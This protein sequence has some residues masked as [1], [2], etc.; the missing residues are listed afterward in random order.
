MLQ[1]NV[2]LPPRLTG[3]PYPPAYDPS[4]SP[5]RQ[6]EVSSA[7]LGVIR[8]AGK[9]LDLYRFWGIVQQAGGSAKV[10][11]C[12]I[13]FAHCACSNLMWQLHQQGMWGQLLPHLDLPEQ[14]LGPNGQ[15]QSTAQVL[16]QYY[17]Q[18]LS[19]FE[20]AY[21][22]N[23]RDQR[24]QGRPQAGFPMPGAGQG[25]ST[26]P[27]TFPPVGNLPAMTGNHDPGMLGQP[28]GGSNMQ[29]PDMPAGGM[30]VPFANGPV[31]LPQR[32]GSQQMPNG[33]NGNLDATA[34]NMPRS[35]TNGLPSEASV[36][37]LSASSSG[38]LDVEGRKR[39]MEEGDEANGKRAR[40]KTGND[41]HY[42]YH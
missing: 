14:M 1:R 35:G 7:D 38:D 37:E 8:L 17:V 34:F 2:P 23:S 3:V 29:V 11:I 19:P 22:K 13:S 10:C 39:K 28:M 15:V 4:S 9:D 27:G 12:S 25:R 24:M 32:P 20:E 16:Q 40:Q 6:L 18:L 36:S 21:R 5:W 33:L 31:P 30:N 41:P 42:L 26:I